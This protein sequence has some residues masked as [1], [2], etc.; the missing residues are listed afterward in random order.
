[1]HEL[2]GEAPI[3]SRAWGV[4]FTFRPAFKWFGAVCVAL[5][6]LILLHYVLGGLD[7]L[8]RRFR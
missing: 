1:M 8:L 6:A 5:L 7:G 3:L 2:R 4:G